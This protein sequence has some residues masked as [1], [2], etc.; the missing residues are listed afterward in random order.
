MEGYFTMDERHLG[1]VRG[2]R[3]AALARLHWEQSGWT[4]AAR[5]TL[6]E[7]WFDWWDR[8][9]RRVEKALALIDS[10]VAEYKLGE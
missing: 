7:Y 10:L 4:T 3:A 5:L 2:R 9:A 6:A 8:E 1:R